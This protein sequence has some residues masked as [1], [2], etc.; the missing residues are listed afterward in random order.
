MDI[1]VF[2]TSEK[3]RRIY[4]EAAEKFYNYPVQFPENQRAYRAALEL[5]GT[6]ESLVFE[7]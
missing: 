7:K 6:R 1:T 4:G 3:A 2:L 5:I